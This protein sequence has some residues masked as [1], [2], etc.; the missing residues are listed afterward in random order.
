[1]DSDEEKIEKKKKKKKEKFIFEDWL[2][3]I[4]QN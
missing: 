3:V 1:L 2:V 4:T